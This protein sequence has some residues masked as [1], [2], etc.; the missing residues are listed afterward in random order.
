MLSTI[1]NFSDPQANTIQETCIRKIEFRIKWTYLAFE[2]L[3]RK[4]FLFSINSM[5]FKRTFSILRKIINNLKKWKLSIAQ[6]EI[7]K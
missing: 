3:L 5:Y 2:Y 4:R 6:Q 1:L 7:L